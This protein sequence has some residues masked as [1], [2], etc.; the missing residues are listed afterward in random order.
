MPTTPTP[1]PYDLLHPASQFDLLLKQASQQ[2]SYAMSSGYQ[3]QQMYPVSSQRG[4]IVNGQPTAELT[5]TVPAMA[6]KIGSTDVPLSQYMNS[7]GV[8]E[9]VHTS[10]GTLGYQAYVAKLLGP[11][12][13]NFGAGVNT[14]PS[15]PSNVPT[16]IGH[17]ISQML[18][19]TI[20]DYKSGLESMLQSLPKQAPTAAVLQGMKDILAFPVSGLSGLA[21]APAGVG[22]DPY[23]AGLYQQLSTQRSGGTVSNT[24]GGLADYSASINQLIGSN[25]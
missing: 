3:P 1:N 17:G 20:G 12:I 11:Y 2:P 22:S 5:P 9:T 25:K 14:N 7:P 6:N 19:S 24:G 13:K 15:Q 21:G 10:P 18:T 16:S 23:L 4:P 8:N